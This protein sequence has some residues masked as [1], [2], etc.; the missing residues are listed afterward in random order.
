MLNK[1]IFLITLISILLIANISAWEWDNSLKYSED[2][3]VVTIENALGLGDVLAQAKLISHSPV[4]EVRRVETGENVVV[5]FY[6]FYNVK[7]NYKNALGEVTFID[8]KTNKEISKSYKF[9]KAVYELVDVPDYSYSCIDIEVDGVNKNVCDT[10]K[11]GTK[12]EN[13]IV[14]WETLTNKDIKKLNS[15]EKIVIGLSTSVIDGDYID[16]V[17]EIMGKKVTKH[18]A[19]TSGLTNGLFAYYNCSSGLDAINGNEFNL[20]TSSGHANYQL[21]V[22]MIEKAC[23]NS[24]LGWFTIN[25]HNKLLLNHTGQQSTIAF[26]FRSNETTGGDR[27]ISSSSFDLTQ[28]GGAGALYLSGF[29]GD[30]LTTSALTTDTW[31]HIVLTKNATASCIF[32]NSVVE[33]CD[34]PAA[35][36]PT[37]ENTTIMSDWDTSG[38]LA[39]YFD[40]MGWWN[41]SLT[42][43]EITQLYNSGAGITYDPSP[44][45]VVSIVYPANTS[46][47]SQRTEL[48]YTYEGEADYCW[49][50]INNGVTNSTP[51][52]AGLNFTG[53]TSSDGSNTWRVYCNDSSNRLGNAS[54]TFY[55]DSTYPSV[56]ITYP[57]NNVIYQVYGNNLTINWTLIDD[58]TTLSNC[59]YYYNS[60][61]ISVDCNDNNLTLNVTNFN[62]KNI[63]LYVNNSVGLINSSYISWNYTLFQWDKQFSSSVD[64]T[65]LQ[66]VTF[67][68]TVPS[69]LIF[70]GAN[71]IYNGSSYT[72]TKVNTAAENY[73]IYTSI[74]IPSVSTSTAK[75]FYESYTLTTGTGTTYVNSSVY[76]H[77]IVNLQAIN[78]TTLACSAGY[79]E[80]VNY[81]FFDEENRTS[82]KNLTL[83]YNFKYGIS[84]ASANEFY[85]EILDTEVLR[86]CV[87]SSANNYELG[88]GEIEYSKSGYTS[89]RFYMYDNYAISNSTTQ[90]YKLYILVNSLATSF[91]FDIENNLLDPLQGKL[92]ALLR[93]YPSVNQYDVVE[94]AKTD[95][96]GQSVMK[97]HTEDVDYRLGIYEIDGTLLKIT[98]P[99]RMACLINPCTYSV[100][101]TSDDTNY[102]YVNNIQSS[103]YYDDTN[104]RFI[105]TWND[106]SQIVDSMRLVVEKDLGYQRVEVCNTTTSGYSGAIA[107]SVVNQTGTFIAKAYKTASP[108]V[109]FATITQTI[110]NLIDNTLG[111]FFGLILSILF[112]LIGIFS[113]I[114]AVIFCL[115]GL[116]PL[117]IFGSIPLQL[118][119]AIGTLGGIII[120]FIG[121]R[122]RR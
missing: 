47:N 23:G 98:D 78:I 16:G 77:T 76:N 59:W 34:S 24:G 74:E 37:G 26:W 63:R 100:K 31:R 27:V 10:R 82:I 83:R 71:L 41:R 104:E 45:P 12:K 3:S 67:N 61:N 114:M 54:R 117:L 87:N 89:R 73:T 102:F 14:R 119:V 56:N 19:W 97:V 1:K 43:A 39:G 70:F 48:N 113:P 30:G 94:M 93:W 64:E 118:M 9:I 17:W 101:V 103:L 111:L 15:G 44:E 51:T 25:E 4:T 55:I 116:I 2:D 109:A 99:V 80:A 58:A 29:D 42:Q 32:I 95:E 121:M 18:A 105:F 106:P 33:V 84:N 66:N 72:S 28:T 11:N 85:G 108:E 21:G 122:Q 6:E 53:L 81:S 40:E 86:L 62:G 60:T 79:F 92:L 110:R 8:K 96:N 69:G 65:S 112:G 120:H 90:E 46:Y 91:L 38:K 20:T 50:S 36:S 57:I 115:I 35:F 49:Y 22:A 107:C 88:Y 68:I 52:T 75:T 13:K 7:E 5:M